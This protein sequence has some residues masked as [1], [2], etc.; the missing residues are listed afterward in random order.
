MTGNFI[1]V[2]IRCIYEGGWDWHEQQAGQDEEGEGAEAEEADTA[3]RQSVKLPEEMRAAM[4]GRKYCAQE[5]LTREVLLQYRYH[6]YL[7]GIGV[8]FP[9][10]MLPCLLI[11]LLKNRDTLRSEVQGNINRA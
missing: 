10:P 2:N 11:C 7:K 4:G 8:D 3:S 5:E 9:L 6:R 1:P